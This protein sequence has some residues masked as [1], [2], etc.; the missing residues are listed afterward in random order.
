M[1]DFLKGTVTEVKEKSLTLVVGG[2]GFSLHVPM[3]KAFTTDTQA[4]LYTYLHWNQENGPSLFGFATPHERTVFLLII[5]CPKIGPSIALNV[6]SQIPPGQFLEIVTSSNQAALSKI[7]GIGEKKAAQII[8]PLKHKVQK[9]INSGSLIIEQQQN[10]VQWHQISEV[11]LS[12]N[13]TRQEIARATQYLGEK[14][15]GQN[16]QLDQL[17]RA[18]LTFLSQKQA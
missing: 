17:I 15:T 5:D 7:N 4:H 10:F 14:Y 1:L 6:L 2:I 11:L 12:L 13:Y 8:V 3:V 9:L 18:A 16:Y